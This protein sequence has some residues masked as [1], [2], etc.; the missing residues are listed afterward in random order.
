MDIE[1]IDAKSY[2]FCA[3]VGKDAVEEDL[4]KIKGCRPGANIS[5]PFYF[6]A[7]YGDARSVGV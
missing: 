5:G 6:M 1:V 3:F 2:K 7:F 4:Q